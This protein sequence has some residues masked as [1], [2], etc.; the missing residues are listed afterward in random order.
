MNKR[1]EIRLGAK[2][3]AQRRWRMQPQPTL[4]GD[5]LREIREEGRVRR[6]RWLRVGGWALAAL[7]TLGA[8]G[9]VL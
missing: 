8:A 6:A 1:L 3:A 9:A 5:R 7:V 4:A 2:L